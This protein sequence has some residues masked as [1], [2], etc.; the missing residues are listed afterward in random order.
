MSVSAV[1][2][3]PAEFAVAVRPRT[4]RDAIRAARLLREQARVA[5]AFGQARQAEVLRTTAREYIRHARL[6]LRSVSH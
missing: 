6:L 1:L 3:G 2:G 5:A 4:Y